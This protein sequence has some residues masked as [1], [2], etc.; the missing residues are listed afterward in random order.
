MTDTHDIIPKAEQLAARD[1]L[2]PLIAAMLEKDPTPETCEKM[3]ALQERFE[4]NE[5]RK[6]YNVAL[7]ALKRDLPAYLARDKDVNFNGKYMYSHTTLAAMMETVMPH[8]IANGFSMTW[9]S[10]APSKPGLIAV[11]A[12]LTHVGGHS[13]RTTLEAPPDTAG[14]KS[15]PQAVASTATMLQRYTALLRLGLVTRD[16]DEPANEVKTKPAAD[17]VN[18]DRNMKAMAELVKAGKTKAQAEDFVKRSVENWTTADLKSL[19]EWV[20]PKK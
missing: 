8:L 7:N 10:P 20:K 15:A 9:D 17:E 5:A 4:A 3:L 19:W 2:H 18:T 1:T 16:I 12:I 13:E 6:A 11:T 14:S